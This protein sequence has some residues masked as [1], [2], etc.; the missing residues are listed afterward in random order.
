MPEKINID[1]LKALVANEIK[2][3][4]F[5]DVLDDTSIEKIVNNILDK[6][7]KENMVN[8]IPDILP[9]QTQP[10][11][12]T[13]TNNM[14]PETNTPQPIDQS[15]SGNIPAYTPDLPSFLDKIEPGKVIVYDM[16]E[17]SHGGENLSYA[18]LR[19]YENPDVKKSMHDLWVEEGKRRAEVFM[20]KLEKIGE[21]EFNYTNGTSQ[22]INNRLDPNFQSLAKYKENPYAVQDAA[23][24]V[25]DMN[26]PTLM[27][28]IS[29]AVD[30]ERVVKDIVM[31]IIRKGM[32][33]EQATH[34]SYGYDTTQAVKPME[35]T[36]VGFTS[37]NAFAHEGELHNQF[38]INMAILVDDNGKYTK[39]ELPL[40]LKEHIGL[41]KRDYLKNEN[42]EVEEW[43][44]EGVSYFLPKNRISKN[45]GYIL[46]K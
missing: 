30:L 11:Q 46:K 5:H 2:N 41:G 35:E 22:F 31:D 18:P 12:E 29:T 8:S 16:N 27:S 26:R 17:I 10:Q 36:V 21:I 39:A 38:N 44:Y 20:V 9:E 19:T 33:G 40:S 32:M 42:S 6:Q 1:E 4:G 37:K 24:K 28:Q 7:K 3:E 23:A 43:G 34:E 25:E 14:T 45:K 13:Q 15:T